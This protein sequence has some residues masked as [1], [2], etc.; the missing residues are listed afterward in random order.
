MRLARLVAVAALAVVTAACGSNSATGSN[1][2]GA[3]SAEDVL[4]ASVAAL[5][6]VSSVHIKGDIESDGEKMS[7]DMHITSTG[8]A[9]GTIKAEGAEISLI[10]AGS[11]IYMKAEADAWESLSGSGE[12]AALL[13]GKWLKLPGDDSDFSEFT[14]FTDLKAFADNLSADGKLTKQ[15]G[16]KTINGKK[17]FVLEDESDDASILYIAA[18]GKPLPLRIEPKSGTDK[19]FL[20]FTYGESITVKAP[21][22]AVDLAALIAGMME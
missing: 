18:T 17:A 4:S 20:D 19:G 3:K 13:A 7:L 14:D 21:A 12:A 8:E 2:L 16:T 10:R 15:P 6:E 1:G 9:Q 5:K 11:D 22:D